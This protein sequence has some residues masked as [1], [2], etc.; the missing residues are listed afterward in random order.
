MRAVQLQW[1]HEVRVQCRRKCSLKLQS[2]CRWLHADCT[3]V[4]CMQIADIL[5]SIARRK[6]FR[7]FSD[8]THIYIYSKTSVPPLYYMGN[9]NIGVLTIITTDIVKEAIILLYGGYFYYKGIR[10][11]VQCNCASICEIVIRQL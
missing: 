7:I 10:S 8:I 3:A 4:G 2:A 5:Q 6:I 9:L 11:T 1:L